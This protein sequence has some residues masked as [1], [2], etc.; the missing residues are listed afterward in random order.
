MRFVL[1]EKNF[2]ENEDENAKKRL[3]GVKKKKNNGRK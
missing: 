2:P 1:I 3:P